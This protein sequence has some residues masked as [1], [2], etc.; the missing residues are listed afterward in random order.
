MEINL[1]W[2][3]CRQDVVSIQVAFGMCFERQTEPSVKAPASL[4][5][6]QQGQFM[7]R[8]FALSISI[9]ICCLALSGVDNPTC[10]HLILHGFDRTCR[11]AS[12]AAAHPAH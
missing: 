7:A 10:T 6:L 11:L 4:P 8:V 5:I 9:L 12:L 2:E 1:G 3:I